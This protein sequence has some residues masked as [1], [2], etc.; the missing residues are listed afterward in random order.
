VIEK[1]I[2]KL[3]QTATVRSLAKTYPLGERTS[4]CI[5]TITSTTPETRVVG[6]RIGKSLTFVP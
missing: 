1:Y 3:D 6:E 4:V 5:M 2:E